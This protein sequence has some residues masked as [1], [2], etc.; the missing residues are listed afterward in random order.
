[1]NTNAN[2]TPKKRAR[3]PALLLA[4]LLAL[5]LVPPPPTPPAGR[6]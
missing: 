3:L 2:Q 5:L 4:A 6:K 1:M